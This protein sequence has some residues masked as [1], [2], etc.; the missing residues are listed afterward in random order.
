MVGIYFSGTGN[1]RYC[2]KRFTS[3]VD[4]NAKCFSIEDNGVI[5]EL[6]KHDTI[7]FGYPVYHSN[8]PKIVKDFIASN[9]GSFR[10]KKVFIIVTRA[11]FTHY[12]VGYGA[13]R[14]KKC[15]AKVIGSLSFRMPENV[16][17]TSVTKIITGKNRDS[18]LI[19]KADSR[20]SLEAHKFANGIYTK[21]GLSLF[22][23]IIGMF[24]SLIH[25]TTNKYIKAPKVNIE[26]CIGCKKCADICPTHNIKIVDNKAVSSDKCTVCYRCC[27]CCPTKALTVMGNKMH[28]QY[29]FEIARKYVT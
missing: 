10:N 13:R 11:L 8:I 19:K 1:T 29:D 20:I 12:A 23:F 6:S 25:P 28:S 17:D 22:N 27:N 5:D 4:E 9:K 24:A 15:G 7:V 3:L 2:V 14:F 18:K 16:R 26:K 21:R